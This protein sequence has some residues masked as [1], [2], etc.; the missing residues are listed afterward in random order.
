MKIIY[1]GSTED[2][3]YTL[4]VLKQNNFEIF[5]I[6]TKNSKSMRRGRETSLTSIENYASEHKI[7][8][9]KPRSLKSDNDLIAYFSKIK[10]DIFVVSSYGIIIPKEILEIPKNGVINIHPSLL[11]KFRGPSPVASAILEGEKFT[12]VTIIKLDE[13]MDTGPILEKSHKVSISSKDSASAL[14][15]KLFRLGSD[16]LPNILRNIEQGNQ[17]FISQNNNNASTTKKINKIDGKIKWNDKDFEII[18]K[19]R[20]YDKW[21]GTFT[22]WNNKRIKII[23]VAE[24]QIDSLEKHGLVKFIDKKIFVSTQNKFLEIK[25]IQFEGKKIM[26]VDQVINGY[27]NLNGSCLD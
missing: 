15:E 26:S 19:V 25:K 11:P 17:S 21:P 22:F 5:T 10:P 3:I 18:R 6:F 8:I 23:D 27:S 12:G 4:D 13:N 9:K 1:F 24:T 2:S 20:A 16:M 14:Q 7:N